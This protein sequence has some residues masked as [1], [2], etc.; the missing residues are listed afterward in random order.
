MSVEKII[1]LIEREAEDETTVIV[2]QAE[3]EAR[4][5]VA[6]ARADIEARVAEALERVGP[7]IRATSQRRINAVRLQVLEGRARDDAARLTAVFDAAESC[8]G[9]IAEGADERRWWAALER[10]CADA[11]RSVGE[12]ASVAIRSR[13]APAVADVASREKAGVEVLPD[14]VPAGLRAISHDGRIEVDARL[15]V[16]VERARSLMAERVARALALEPG[17]IGNG[18]ER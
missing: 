12:G 15:A 9:E 4:E 2:A 18:S 14:D 17:D 8:A 7:E 13:D 1:Q 5:S 10:L 16:R 6:A 3:R 11:L